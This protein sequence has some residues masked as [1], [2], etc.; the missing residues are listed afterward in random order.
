MSNTAQNHALYFPDYAIVEFLRAHG[1]GPKSK[2]Y[3]FVVALILQKFCQ[4]Q[5]KE[6]CQI[7]FKIKP[8]Y[9]AALPQ[10]GMARLAMPN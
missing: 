3:E 9:S 10:L 6:P 4:K 7:G 2:H 1:K 5:W 8:K